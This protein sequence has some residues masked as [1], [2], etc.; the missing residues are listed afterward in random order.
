MKNLALKKT[1]EM[2]KTYG[3]NHRSFLIVLLEKNVAL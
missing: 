3:F 1:L 2:S